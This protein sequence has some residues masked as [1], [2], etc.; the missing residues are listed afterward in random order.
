MAQECCDTDEKD[1]SKKTVLKP[2]LK[3]KH[4]HNEKDH[5]HEPG[6][7]HQEG[8]GHDHGGEDAAGWKT[9]IGRAHV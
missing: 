1:K 5:D 6:D 3:N 9:Q 7:E 2:V 4:D 8:D